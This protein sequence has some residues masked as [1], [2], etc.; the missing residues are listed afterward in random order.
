MNR[1]RFLKHTLVVLS[2]QLRNLTDV[3]FITRAMIL[4]F[5]TYKFLPFSLTF[6]LFLTNYYA[7]VYILGNNR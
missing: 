7:K 2:E 1:M 5:Q 4:N 3:S 6:L